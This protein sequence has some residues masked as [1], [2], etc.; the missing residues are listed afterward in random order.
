MDTNNLTRLLQDLGFIVTKR[1][2][3]T[4]FVS[5][6]CFSNLISCVRFYT[7][8]LF[9]GFWLVAFSTCLNVVYTSKMTIVLH[10]LKFI[11]YVIKIIKH[12][13]NYI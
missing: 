2:N 9:L 11:Y 6:A 5:V 1:E 4:K 3:L 13:Y 7:L 12:T 8:Y 10:C